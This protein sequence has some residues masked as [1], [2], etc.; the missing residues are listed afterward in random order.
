MKKIIMLML[1]A[2][3][4]VSFVSAGNGVVDSEGKPIENSLKNLD[5]AEIQIKSTLRSQELVRNMEKFQINHQEKL[6]DCEENCQ[7]RLETS[8]G[9]RDTSMLQIERKAKF[10]WIPVNLVA[11][12]EIDSDGD[13]VNER[14]NFWQWAYEFRL[15]DLGDAE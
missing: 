1:I 3:L 11:D 10:L 5:Q 9:Q 14:R 13:I 12:Y 4:C 6:Y 8:S 7:I 2:I 15:V